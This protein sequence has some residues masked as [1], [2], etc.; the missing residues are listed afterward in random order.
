MFYVFD[1]VC[2]CFVCMSVSIYATFVQ[3]QQRSREDFRFT[4]TGVTDGCEPSFEC[5]NLNTGPLEKE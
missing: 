2:E 1:Y 3:Y 5:L 4:S